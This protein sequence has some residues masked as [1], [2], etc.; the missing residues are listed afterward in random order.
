MW[1]LVGLFFKICDDFLV[2]MENFNGVE[3][4]RGVKKKSVPG[5]REGLTIASLCR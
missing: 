1:E 3:T 4:A 5:K 2:H